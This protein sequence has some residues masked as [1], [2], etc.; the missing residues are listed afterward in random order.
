MNKPFSLSFHIVFF[1]LAIF[2]LSLIVDIPAKYLPILEILPF[3][4]LG[5]AFILGYRF[6]RSLVIYS[7]VLFILVYAYPSVSDQLNKEQYYLSLNTLVIFLVMNVTLL[8]FY[9]ERGIFTL[10]G[11]S[12][13]VFIFAQLG[14]IIWFVEA[15]PVLWKSLILQT[16]FPA[17]EIKLAFFEQLTLLVILSSI[18]LISSSYLTRANP[19]RS[20][21]FVSMLICLYA[22]TLPAKEM[23][24]YSALLSYALLLPLLT[25]I[26]ESYR[27]AFIDELTNLPG[28]RALNEAMDKLGKNYVI[29]MLD[30]DHFKKFNDTYG[31][32]AGDD[33]LQLL[34]SRL[35]LVKGGGKPFRY[36]GE[37][38][39]ILFSGVTLKG[40]KEHLDNLREEIATKKFALRKQERR[41]KNSRAAKK[42]KQRHVSV[43]I[44]IGFAQQNDK[45][46]SPAAVL[47]A[48]DKA[49]YRAKKKGRNCVSK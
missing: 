19:F 18:I 13:F 9:C 23:L 38:F 49:L 22:I 3:A 12:R 21:I 15:Q 2:S 11:M 36:G 4:L 37:E 1:V 17:L 30:V 14:V 46:T 26:S 48:S 44:S 16:I 7:A 24:S 29:A 31:H 5:L 25:L 40:A 43:T 33:V 42:K 47:K 41:N 8:C 39:A 10:I 6:N 27:M 20:A 45:L 32:D 28:R 35:K 34:G